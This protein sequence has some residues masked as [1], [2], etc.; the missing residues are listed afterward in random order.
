MGMRRIRK[1]R[2]P[3]RTRVALIVFEE[4]YWLVISSWPSLSRVS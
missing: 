3:L 4:R 1:A 2:P